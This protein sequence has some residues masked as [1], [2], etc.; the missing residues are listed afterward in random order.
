VNTAPTGVVLVV[1]LDPDNRTLSDSYDDILAEYVREDP[2]EVPDDVLHRRTAADPG[3]VLSCG[4]WPAITQARAAGGRLRAEQLAELGDL[5]GTA[6]YTLDPPE[7]KPWPPPKKKA[8]KKAATKAAPP[9]RRF[10]R[11]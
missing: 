5:R 2:Q 9:R 3:K 1:G 10:L 6:D 7:P 4:V 11:R 8:A